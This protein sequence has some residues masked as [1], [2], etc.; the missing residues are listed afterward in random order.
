MANEK[1]AAGRGWTKKLA[2]IAAP[3]VV[4]GRYTVVRLRRDSTVEIAKS[5]ETSRAAHQ[6]ATRIGNDTD[7]NTYVATRR[8]G[9]VA[10]WCGP[11]A[12]LTAVD[13]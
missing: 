6:Q 10:I 2:T 4:E 13:L 1:K 11:S 12:L 5:Y 9:R 7:C 8:G 3:S